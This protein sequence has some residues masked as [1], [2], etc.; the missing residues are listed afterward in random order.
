LDVAEVTTSELTEAD[1]AFAGNRL[2]STFAREARGLL[3]PFG[4]LT[5]FKS[6]DVVLKRGEQVESAA[7]EPSAASSVAATRRLFRSQSSSSAVRLS[8]F[9]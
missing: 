9:R 1:E 8:G 5:Q 4:E 6:G 7:R 3:E 2:L